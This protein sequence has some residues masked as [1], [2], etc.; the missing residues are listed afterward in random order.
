MG[1][2]I[3]ERVDTKE[4]IATIVDLARRG[5]LD[6]IDGKAGGTSGKTGI[7]YK[8]LKPLDELQGFEKLV[9]ES[10]FDETHPDQVTNSDLKNHFYV[11]VPPIV[12]QVYEDV[13]TA[14][15]FRRT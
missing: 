2:L 1:A 10:L 4:V 15:L 3:D 13:T 6:M 11:H 12:A 5:Y 9:A 7:T 14:G 8:R